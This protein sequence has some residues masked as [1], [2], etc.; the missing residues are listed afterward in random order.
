[1][2]K[3]DVSFD[4]KKESLVELVKNNLPSGYRILSTGFGIAYIEVGKNTLKNW[5]FR[6]LSLSSDI[7]FVVRWLP[8]KDILDLYVYK[9]EN[10]YLVRGLAEKLEKEKFIKNEVQLFR[11]Y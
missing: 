3:E 11:G 10:Y 4:I 9:K 1:M 7:E 5:L 8:E 2:V 6:G